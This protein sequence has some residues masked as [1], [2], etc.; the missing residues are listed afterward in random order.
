MSMSLKQSYDVSLFHLLEGPTL[1]T[2]ALGLRACCCF[3]TVCVAQGICTDCFPCSS[4]LQCQSALVE[5]EEP[6]C[7]T[8]LYSIGGLPQ[9]APGLRYVRL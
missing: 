6:V 1:L 5:T 9:L 3:E 2:S 8:S 4:A 7:Q